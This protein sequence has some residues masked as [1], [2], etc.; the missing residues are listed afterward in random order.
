ML[1]RGASAQLEAAGAW[2]PAGPAPV[3][4][5]ARLVA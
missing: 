1:I 5:A 4:V 2:A 3:S